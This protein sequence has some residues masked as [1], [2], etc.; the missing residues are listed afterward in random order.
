[1]PWQRLQAVPVRAGGP[2]ADAAVRGAAQQV[3]RRDA[4]RWREEAHCADSAIAGAH[5]KAH[6]RVG[7]QEGRAGQR[8]HELVQPAA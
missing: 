2:D 5:Q 6:V 1:M 7:L 8:T 3:R 4:G